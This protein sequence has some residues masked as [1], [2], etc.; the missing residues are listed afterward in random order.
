M[1]AVA[2]AGALLGAK[3]LSSGT[4]NSRDGRLV[5]YVAGTLQNSDL[6]LVRA[7]GTGRRRL[8]RDRG[9]ERCPAWSPDG[10]TLTAAVETK[11]QEVTAIEALTPS[12]RERW[13]IPAASCPI[14]SPAGDR[15]LLARADGVYLVDANGLNARRLPLPLDEVGS[16][17]AWWPDGSELAY[18]LAHSDDESDSSKALTIIVRRA[19]GTGSSCHPRH[20]P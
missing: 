16:T 11:S 10:S 19:D 2:L 20:S 14:W 13:R 3:A 15:I 17:P 12:G 4:R 8:T 5:A 6:Y 9:N 1:L 18:A 7:D